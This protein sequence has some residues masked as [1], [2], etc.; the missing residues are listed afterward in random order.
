MDA[1]TGGS[2]RGGE[3]MGH[4]QSLV[5]PGVEQSSH[6]VENLG[7]KQGTVL[8]KFFAQVSQRLS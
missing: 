8:G 2:V 5:Q 1:E 3:P 6:L 7:L 4:F